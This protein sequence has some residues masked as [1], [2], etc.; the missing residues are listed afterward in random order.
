MHKPHF[1]TI[2]S[3][4]LCFI[5]FCGT[6]CKKNGN[7]TIHSASITTIPTGMKCEII[8]RGD[9]VQ[10]LDRMV[11]PNHTSENI[12]GSK[13][14]VYGCILNVGKDW[15]AVSLVDIKVEQ[16]GNATT[17]F[18]AAGRLQEYVYYVPQQNIAYIRTWE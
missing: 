1:C 13:D 10:G 16:N 12:N 7:T 6:G 2:A 4:M 14:S 18:G 5:V 3:I 8:L 15:V 9:V 11:T 17:T